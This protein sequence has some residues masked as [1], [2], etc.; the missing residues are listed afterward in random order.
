ME[1]SEGYEDPSVPADVTRLCSVTRIDEL[2]ARSWHAGTQISIWWCSLYKCLLTELEVSYFSK[3]FK[4]ASEK[5]M[6]A[7]AF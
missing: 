2:P 4:I 1:H 7:F 5:P 6:F 3:R